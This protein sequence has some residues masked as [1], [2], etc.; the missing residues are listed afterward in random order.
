MGAA[1]DVD[2]GGT[3]SKLGVGLLTVGTGLSSVMTMGDVEVLP[4][5]SRI[6][7]SIRPCCHSL[8]GTAAPNFLNRDE[9]AKNRVSG[10][11]LPS[12][13]AAAF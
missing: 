2:A 1:V 12:P 10:D 3:T 8:S 7:W 6:P 13:A 4:G 11:F 5:E 9:M